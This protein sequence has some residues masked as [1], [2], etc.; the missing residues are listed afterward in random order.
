ME[1]TFK[2]GGIT[3]DRLWREYEEEDET[4]ER[5]LSLCLGLAEKRRKDNFSRDEE[6]ADVDI[7]QLRNITQWR[8]FLMTEERRNCKDGVIPLSH[9][10][11]SGDT[12][13]SYL[14]LPNITSP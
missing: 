11:P 14:T 9:W 3:T 10:P 7:E 12:T 1:W 8:K 4:V 6:I 2:D 13:A 5:L